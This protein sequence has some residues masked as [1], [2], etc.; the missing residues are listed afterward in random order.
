MKIPEPFN[1]LGL[2]VAVYLVGALAAPV[3]IGWGV[4]KLYKWYRRDEY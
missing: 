4:Y 3:A 2:A 1:I